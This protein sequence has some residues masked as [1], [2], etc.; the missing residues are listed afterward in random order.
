[1]DP[2]TFTAE[3]WVWEAKQPSTG[4]IFVTVPDEFTEEIRMLGGPSKGFGSVRVEVTVGDQTWRTSVFPESGR[5]FVLPV[6]APVRR[7]AGVEA[8]DSIDVTLRVIGA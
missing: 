5:G 3:L 8:G 1:M 7:H 4:W 2:L 6:K